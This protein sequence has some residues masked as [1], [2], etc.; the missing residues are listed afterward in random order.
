MMEDFRDF[1]WVLRPSAVYV[2]MWKGK[3]VYVGQ[4]TNIANRLSVHWAN[5]RRVRR[6]KRPYNSGRVIDFAV[7]FD[8]VH[9]K[10]V[11]Q[12]W[13]DREEQALIDRFAPKY[14]T[15]LKRKGIPKVQIDDLPFFQELLASGPKP[16]PDFRR[17]PRG[18]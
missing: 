15:L 7:Q 5:M 6:G 3:V 12:R 4:S 11:D 17:L 16:E 18:F 2:L 10:F 8:E 9:V 13:L 1:S 14:N